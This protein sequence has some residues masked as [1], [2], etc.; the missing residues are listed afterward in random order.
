[1]YMKK[2]IKLTESNIRRIVR[3]SVNRVL[4]EVDITSWSYSNTDTFTKAIDILS[5]SVLNNILSGY[6]S[7]LKLA[8]DLDSC[9]DID[10]QYFFSIVI[11]NDYSFTEPFSI[12]RFIREHSN[13]QYDIFEDY[14]KENWE[15]ILP[16]DMVE[17]IYDRRD[18]A[19]ITHSHY[20]GGGGYEVMHEL[21]AGVRERVYYKIKS[22]FM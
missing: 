14:V 1:M 11:E 4:K 5:D 12:K 6:I 9:D 8:T 10:I 19:S 18:V 3:E 15:D 2:R 20:L 21:Q 7:E 22:K 17:D 16:E 13:E